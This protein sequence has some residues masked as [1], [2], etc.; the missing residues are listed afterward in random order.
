MLCGII[1]KIKNLE[2]LFR[3]NK[4][5]PLLKT[6]EKDFQLNWSMIKW[7]LCT[8]ISPTSLFAWR[9]LWTFPTG[10]FHGFVVINGILSND[11]K[12]SC[13][14]SVNPGLGFIGHFN[15]GIPVGVCWRELLG[16]AWIYGEVNKEGLFSGKFFT[17]DNWTLKKHARKLVLVI[18][19]G[20]LSKSTDSY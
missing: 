20:I 13:A 10:K 14:P 5:S 11:P 12:S 8:I 1:W 2:K 7:I 17:S 3:K 4:T 16:G 9:H 6:P 18:Y 19:I 15:D